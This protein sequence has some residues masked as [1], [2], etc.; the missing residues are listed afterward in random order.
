M[1][2][3]CPE[4][5]CLWIPFAGR[6]GWE[7]CTTVEEGCRLPVLMLMRL[8]RASGV[9]QDAALDGSS[10]VRLGRAPSVFFLIQ[11]ASEQ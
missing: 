1:D 7:V 5:V 11:A 4:D 6:G 3:P 8:P 9:M 10:L 2:P